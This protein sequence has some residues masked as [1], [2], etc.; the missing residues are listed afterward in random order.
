M[1]PIQTLK[2]RAAD[3]R[4][5]AIRAAQAEYRVTLRQLK[6]LSASLPGRAQIAPEPRTR[7]R[8]S[9]TITRLILEIM[10][11]DQAFTT[12]ELLELLEHTDPGRPFN[13]PTIRT[14]VHR[15]VQ[16][17]AMQRVRKGG[18]GHIYYAAAACPITDYGPFATMSIRDIVAT[19]LR[20]KGPMRPVEAM[21][22]IQ[23]GGY[24]PDAD[25]RILLQMV[26]QAFKRNPSRF[27][28]SGDG[29]WSS[30]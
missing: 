20:E 9:Q 2:Q 6:E 10:P 24:R 16:Q 14:V 4:D 5:K 3:K 15:L 23:E 26:S 1:D 25:K 30:V 13:E 27:T 29:K 21:L 11:K 8:R 19:V 28:C 22:A 17:G 7:R 12:R 18:R